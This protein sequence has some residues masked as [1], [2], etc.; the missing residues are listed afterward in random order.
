MSEEKEGRLDFSKCCNLITEACCV[1]KLT[2]SH[3]CR[4]T[5]GKEKGTKKLFLS[6]RKH[7]NIPKK[8]VKP[9]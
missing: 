3:I 8:S 4:E 5:K 1:G 9:R 2:V 7:I 6:P